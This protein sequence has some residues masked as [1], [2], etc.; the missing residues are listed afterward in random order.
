MSKPL[1]IY[2]AGPYTAETEDQR[3]NN[4]NV[5][6]DA[7]FEL[8]IRGH[9]P[10]IP[11]LTH[12]IDHR[13][14]EVGFLLEWEDYIRWDMVWLETCDALLYLGSSRGANLELDAAK[15]AG[16]QIFYSLTEIPELNV[17]VAI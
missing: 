12:F 5:A 4:V 2:I 8:L 9:F 7:S 10:Y 13:A 11:H 1:K 16:K 6:I 15:R 17:E 3:V 14:K